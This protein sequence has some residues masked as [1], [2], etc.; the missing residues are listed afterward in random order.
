[1][2]RKKGEVRGNK[3]YQDENSKQCHCDNGSNWV[4]KLSTKIVRIYT[5]QTI[6]ISYS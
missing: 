5:E 2:D 3:E 1:M 6:A 4:E